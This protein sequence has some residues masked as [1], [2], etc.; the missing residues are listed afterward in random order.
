MS[1]PSS[2][3]LVLAVASFIAA[4]NAATA[5]KP[6]HVILPDGKVGASVETISRTLGTSSAQDGGVSVTG[7]LD[8]VLSNK[9]ATA[10]AL[11]ESSFDPVG[12][13]KF[14]ILLKD[15]HSIQL[16]YSVILICDPLTIY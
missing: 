9:V 15:I 4:A 14:T 2:L 16:A 12:Q 13:L 11:F 7:V 10:N 6:L 1:L 3:T 8:C 5:S